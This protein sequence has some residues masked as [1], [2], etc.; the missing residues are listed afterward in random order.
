[1][2]H[3]AISQVKITQIDSSTLYK[4]TW[5]LFYL[6]GTELLD[7]DRSNLPSIIFYPG[8]NIKIKGWLGCNSFQGTA[9]TGLD[10][11]LALSIVPLSSHSCYGNDP[12]VPFYNTL[13]KVDQFVIKNNELRFYHQGDLL[14]RFSPDISQENAYPLIGLS[15]EWKVVLCDGL[16]NL[17]DYFK[18]WQ[19]TLS[20]NTS[21]PDSVFAFSGCRHFTS[22]LRIEDQKFYVGTPQFSGD[23]ICEKNLEAIFLNLL[24]EVNSYLFWND[25]MYLKKGGTMLM[26]LDRSMPIEQFKGAAIRF[27]E[28]HYKRHPVV[29][30]NSTP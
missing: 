29:C 19:P 12:D 21:H 5:N 10:N 2:S 16:S 11:R 7:I 13:C 8:E 6:R 4:Y 24:S 14:A 28:K 23:K 26:Q 15:G 20:F 3:P 25:L 18:D 27:R 22:T 9:R 17:K 30:G 1:V